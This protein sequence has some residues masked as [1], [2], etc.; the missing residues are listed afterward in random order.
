MLEST[1]ATRGC[2]LSLATQAS[3]TATTSWSLSSLRPEGEGCVQGNVTMGG[4]PLGLH[5][6][7][8]W[9]QVM[10]HTC[11]VDDTRCEPQKAGTM[12]TICKSAH[13]THT[14]HRLKKKRWPGGGGGFG[15]RL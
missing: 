6:L 13:C 14:L 12:K 1:S 11:K 15:S 8:W 4:R 7:S 5:R 9:E 10:V 3:P 2:P